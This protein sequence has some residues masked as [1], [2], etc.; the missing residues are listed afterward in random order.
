LV[1]A[2]MHFSLG[3]CFENM[4]RLDEA[5]KEYETSL[6]YNPGNDSA[7]KGSNRV[8]VEKTLKNWGKDKEIEYEG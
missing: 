4:G 8:K 2:E 5:R 6:T 7:R 1:K 3:Y